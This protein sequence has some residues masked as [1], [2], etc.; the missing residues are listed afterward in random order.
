MVSFP[1]Q[2]Y[3]LCKSKSFTWAAELYT[4]IYR[5]LL[6]VPAQLQVTPR[7]CQIVAAIPSLPLE[8][9]PKKNIFEGDNNNNYIYL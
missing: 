1:K 9:H 5:Q 6:I 7:F 3:V 2:C 8:I 4:C